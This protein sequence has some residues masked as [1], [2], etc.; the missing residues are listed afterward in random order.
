[1]VSHWLACPDLSDALLQLSE[2][3]GMFAIVGKDVVR[4]IVKYLSKQDAI[5]FAQVNTWF[6]TTARRNRK[7][8]KKKK[9]N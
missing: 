9:K 7:K 3:R 2:M 8:K 4:L 6:H 5:S 1:M